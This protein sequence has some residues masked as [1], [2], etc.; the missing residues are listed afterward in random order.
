MHYPK[1]ILKLLKFYNI[2]TMFN[3]FYLSKEC[4]IHFIYGNDKYP[5]ARALQKFQMKALLLKSAG[6]W[7]Q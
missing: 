1:T 5:L 3:N 6:L 2:Y 4:I 7:V